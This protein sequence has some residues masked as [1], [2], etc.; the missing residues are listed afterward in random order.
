MSYMTYTKCDG[1]EVNRVMWEIEYYETKGGHCPVND[2]L[3]SI[4][5]KMQAKAV[6]NMELLEQFGPFLT[7]PYSRP[8]G[9][10]LYELRVQVSGGISRILYFFCVDQKIIMTNGFIKKTGITPKGELEKALKYRADYQGRI[11]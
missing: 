11:K 4:P 2:F 10:G 5:P 7:M 8:M 3:N 6:R 9:D 1:R